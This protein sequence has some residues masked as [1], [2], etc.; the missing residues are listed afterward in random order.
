[1]NLIMVTGCHCAFNANTLNTAITKENKK[2]FKSFKATAMKRED[3]SALK[4][5]IQEREQQ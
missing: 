4:M 5:V 1:M 3:T 2:T